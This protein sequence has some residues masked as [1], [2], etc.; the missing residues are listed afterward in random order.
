MISFGHWVTTGVL[1]LGGV[2][3]V[4]AGVA[5]WMGWLKPD[6]QAMAAP[7]GQEELT[8]T[9]VSVVSL[10]VGS[11][12]AVTAWGV[13]AWRSWGRILTIIVCAINLLGL[14]LLSFMVPLPVAAIVSGAVT[15]LV[16]LWLFD[17]RVVTAFA[18]G[19]R[20]Q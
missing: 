19:G 12:L 11:L 9:L 20:Q 10:L 15:V 3:Q 6:L 1:A 5:Y 7:P 8:I 13:F 4:A 14:V 18:A 2:T 17:P 16:L